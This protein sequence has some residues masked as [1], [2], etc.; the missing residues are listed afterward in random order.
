MSVC[1][2]G[3]SGPSDAAGTSADPGLRPLPRR[4]RVGAPIRLDTRWVALPAW[5]SGPRL[6]VEQV[7][8]PRSEVLVGAGEL[9]ES[10]PEALELPGQF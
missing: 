4:G 10:G 6:S 7:V 2:E 3:L 5:T 9:P 8:R 1:S